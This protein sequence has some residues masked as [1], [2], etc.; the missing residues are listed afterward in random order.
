MNY[1]F[2]KNTKFLSRTF[3]SR[4]LISKYSDFDSSNPI[5]REAITF[6]AGLTVAEV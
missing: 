6:P 2:H 4:P 5:G 1:I 3:N